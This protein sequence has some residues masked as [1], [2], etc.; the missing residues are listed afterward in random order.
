MNTIAVPP[1]CAPGGVGLYVFCFSRAEACAAAARGPGL[2][3][4]APL[5]TFAR[6]AVAALCC[7]VP[8]ADWVG[9]SGE[10]N[11]QNLAWLGPRAL[12]HEEVIER[13]MAASPV[14]PVR[15]GCLF[16]SAERLQ[17]LL[18][19]AEGRIANFLEGA[20]DWEE[21]SVKGTVDMAACL[22]VAFAEE[23]CV[24]TLPESPGARYL[25][26]QRLRQRAT[27]AAR[28]WMKEASAEVA[29]EVDGV[30]LERRD[31]G[32]VARGTGAEGR[33]VVLHWALRLSRGAE[34]ELARRLSA[35]ES[36]LS[37]RGLCL[38]ARGPWPPYVFAPRLDEDG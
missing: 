16:S 31:A 15:F 34:P 10:A 17:D 33:E 37:A 18:A 14:L 35:L 28:A 1:G 13:A 27:R 12:R 20:A 11:L 23:R 38:E 8:L 26:E 4:G 2:A 22:E 5:R 29:K 25:V 30:A 6:G 24:A 7:E 32:R 21:W 9:P 19:R 36:R 3:E